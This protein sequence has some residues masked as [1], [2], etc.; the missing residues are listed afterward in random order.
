MAI[1]ILESVAAGMDGVHLPDG[2][3][4]NPLANP[5]NGSAGMTLVAELSHDLV[6]VGSGHELADLMD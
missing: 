6:F 2:A 5:A 1:D 4:P 3:G